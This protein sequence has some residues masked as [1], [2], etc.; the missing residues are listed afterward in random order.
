MMEIDEVCEMFV[1]SSTFTCLIVR[2][3]F[4]MHSFYLLQCLGNSHTH[5]HYNL[6]SYVET[7]SCAG[8]LGVC[9]HLAGE[10]LVVSRV[11]FLRY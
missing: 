2:K 10:V 9:S 3:D 11:R 7:V 8:S 5:F 1:F 4:S 6:C